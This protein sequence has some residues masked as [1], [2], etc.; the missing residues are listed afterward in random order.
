MQDNNK[1]IKDT[2][3]EVLSKVKKYT[4]Q[5]EQ[6]SNANERFFELLK[7]QE[8]VINGITSI[9]NECK[10]FCDSTSKKFDVEGYQVLSE[11]MKILSEFVDKI[12]DSH[13][14]IVI[15]F[16]NSY[17]SFDK[18]FNK[19]FDDLNNYQSSIGN[20]FLILNEELKNKTIMLENVISNIN[21]TLDSINYIEKKAN[22]I[23]ETML[24]EFECINKSI[25]ENDKKLKKDK[26][27]FLF[28]SGLIILLQLII[29]L[30]FII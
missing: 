14:D 20:D 29:L 9:T 3:D 11:K 16:Q 21:K 12:I 18:K 25:V 23:Q 6:F 17:N 1:I 26:T 15:K 27:I 7:Q 24:K 28:V 8:D 5:S 10:N 13:N 4:D 2:I 19:L 22:L 30:I